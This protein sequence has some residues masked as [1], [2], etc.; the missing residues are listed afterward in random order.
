ML[1]TPT[2]RTQPIAGR[3]SYQLSVTPDALTLVEG[4]P[5]PAASRLLVLV[6][7]PATSIELANRIWSLAATKKEVEV[8]FMGAAWENNDLYTMRRLL[9]TLAAA[10]RDQQVRVE[11]RLATGKNWLQAIRAVW[12]PG[13]LIICHREQAI[14]AW[15]FQRLPLAEAIAVTFQTPVY[16][17]TGHYP[18]RPPAQPPWR[19]T[20]GRLLRFLLPFL[21]IAGSFGLQLFIGKSFTNWLYDVLMILSVAVELG[22]LALWHERLR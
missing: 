8:L 15:G 7:G 2:T 9:A 3:P 20:T 4:Q 18:E 16:V 21:I 19:V 1:T 11:T 14:T 13:D 17:L 5:L 22:L 10:T 12:Q 6:P